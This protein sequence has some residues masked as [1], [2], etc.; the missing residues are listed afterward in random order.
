MSLLKMFLMER[1][2]AEALCLRLTDLDGRK[3]SPGDVV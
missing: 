1:S 3:R 2:A